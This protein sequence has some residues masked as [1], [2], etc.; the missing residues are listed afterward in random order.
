MPHSRRSRQRPGSAQS[1]VGDGR[2]YGFGNITGPRTHEPMVGRL[3][4]LRCQF[5]G[6]AEIVQDYLRALTTDEQIHCGPGDWI[7]LDKWYVGRII[8][9]GD[10]AHASSPMMGQGGCMAMEDARVLADKL[11]KCGSLGR[12]ASLLCGATIA[13]RALGPPGKPPRRP[14][15]S[16]SPRSCGMTLCARR[17]PRCSSVGSGRSYRSREYSP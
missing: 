7:E 16:S 1:P 2:T 9:I 5:A 8:L 11:V 15:A 10:A 3:D 4:R 12:R 17:A 6:F 13:A 14:S